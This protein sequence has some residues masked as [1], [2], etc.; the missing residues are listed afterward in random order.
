VLVHNLRPQWWRGSVYL[1]SHALVNR[2]SPRRMF[3][4]KWSSL[5]GLA[6]AD[7]VPGVCIPGYPCKPALIR[8]MSTAIVDRGVALS[9][10]GLI[11][12]RCAG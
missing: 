5:P 3:C 10:V 8:F 12:R 2:R 1:M 6:G 7:L 4:H 9:A 11:T